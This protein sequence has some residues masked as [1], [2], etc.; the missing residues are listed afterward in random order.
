M[1]VE[2][3]WRT[4]PAL[5]GVLA[6]A[7]CGSR[8]AEQDILDHLDRQGVSP[9]RDR[10]SEPDAGASAPALPE[11]GAT[12]E[13]L[14]RHAEAVNPELQ[15]ARSAAGAAAGRAW[16]ARL[17]PNPEVGVRAEDIGFREGGVNT[18]VSV[19]QPIVIGGRLRASAAAMRAE[20]A[21]RLAEVERVRREVLGRIAG[22]HARVLD[23]AAQIAMADELMG[24][25]GRTLSIAE[26]RFA[27]RAV[28]EPDVLRPRIE[29]AQ[30]RADRQ[31]LARELESAE[32]QLGLEVGAGPIVAARLA[33]GLGPDAR[34]LDEGTL[35]AE[36]ASAHPSMIV[37]ALEVEAAEAALE[38][39]RAERVPDL[40]VSAGAG[41]SEEGDQGLAEFGVS[42]EIPI[43]DRRQGDLLALRYDIVRLRQAQ[44]ARRNELLAR[45]A[46]EVG[47]Y[48]AACDELS[49]LRESVVPDAERAF[50]QIDEAY[51]A[52]RASFID[53][54][55]AQRTLMQARRTMTGLRGRAAVARARIGAIV[56]PEFL[57]PPGRSA[58]SHSESEPQTAPE[59]AED[60]P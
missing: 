31:R 37:A 24:V 55:D 34:P 18:L 29:L 50:G 19:S 3:R 13:D 36:V 26:E 25:A 8:L 23:L 11:G 45:L 6:G 12:L 4:I 15:S 59:G 1:R 17:Y 53:L 10:V 39:V 33:P 14:M 42:A 32:R 7:G 21:V 41:Y 40:R 35:R 38:R 51:R 52:G 47:E 30:L 49:V 9:P 27:A 44:A 56:G 43:W 46:A 22:L 48:N 16:Q 5:L 57:V 58:G 2:H 20:E 28:A 60:S 54:L